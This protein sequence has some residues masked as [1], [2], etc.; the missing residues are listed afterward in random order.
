MAARF[1]LVSNFQPAGDQPQAIEKIVRSEEHTSE[2]Q[3]PYELVCRLLREKKHRQTRQLGRGVPA[4]PRRA[5]VGRAVPATHELRCGTGG[6]RRSRA[7]NM[8][9]ALPTR[10]TILPTAS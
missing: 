9:V 8:G 10:R 2:L 7:R 4:D 6:A 5:R 3:S 1:E